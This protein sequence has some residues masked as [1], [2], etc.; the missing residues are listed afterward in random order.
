MTNTL[1][2]LFTYAFDLFLILIFF[3]N[4]LQHRKANVPGYIFYGSYCIM[5]MLLY[6][7]ET[8]TASLSENQ[9]FL[10]SLSVSFLTSYALTFLYQSSMRHR[11]FSAISFQFFATLGES[12]FSML[13]GMIRPSI[14]SIDEPSLF[15]IMNLGS[16]VVLFLLVLLVSLFWRRKFSGQNLNYHIF[17]LATPLVSL[18]V[19]LFTPLEDIITGHNRSLF[20]LCLYIT[21]SLLNM[22]NYWFLMKTFRQEQELHRLRQMETQVAYQKERYAQLG[23]AYK[24]NRRLIHDTKKHY[25]ILQEH[26]KRQEYEELRRYLQISME[27]IENTYTEINTGN[28]VIDAFVSNFKNIAQTGGIRFSSTLQVDSDRIPVNDYDLCVVLGNLLDNSLNACRKNAAV[29]NHIALTVTVNENDIFYIHME[30]TYDHAEKP[31]AHQESDFREHGYGIA[32]IQ[33]IVEKYHGFVKYEFGDLFSMDIIIPII[34]VKKR[35]HPPVNHP[36]V[37][38]GFM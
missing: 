34:D 24:T 9:S 7:N 8:L 2:T 13:M 32:N 35:L 25:F 12:I 16:K 14:F 30:N 31:A 33:N 19:M 38:D 21:L 17:I 11:L 20:F 18:T 1:I 3:N 10:L 36:P 26:L 28:L 22:L 6:A 37:M 23:A 15:V 5:E 27:D 4:T 29:Q